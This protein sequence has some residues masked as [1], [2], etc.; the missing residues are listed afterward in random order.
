MPRRSLARRSSRASVTVRRMPVAASGWPMAM[1]PPLTLSLG[2]VEAE[3]AR[4]RHHCAPKASLISKRSMSASAQPGDLASNARIAG[5]GPM[6]MISGAQPMATPAT[7]RA[8]GSLP[9]R[10]RR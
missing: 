3:L 7:S 6:P 8:S 9:L 1:A 10:A 2:F 4:A 5:T